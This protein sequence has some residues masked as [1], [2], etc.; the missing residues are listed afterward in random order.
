[1]IR[2]LAQFQEEAAE[3]GY[4]QDF[5]AS[6]KTLSEVAEADP[7]I[8]ASRSFDLGTDPGDDVTVYLIE[9]RGKNGYLIVSDSFHADPLKAALIAKMLDRG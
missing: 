9:A 8:V 7:H 5:G 1:M 2:D 3:R 4:T 6:D